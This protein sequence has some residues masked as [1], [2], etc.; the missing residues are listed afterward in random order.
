MKRK[1]EYKPLLFTT[2]LRNPSR[3]KEFLGVFSRFDGQLLTNEV[4]LKI[5]GALISNKLYVTTYQKHN[6]KLNGIYLNEGARYSDR[7]ITD[8]LTHSEQNHKEAGFDRGWPSRFDTWFKFLKELGFLYYEMN[9]TI[10]ISPTGKLLLKANEEG[11]SEFESQAFLNAFV[12]YQ[13]NNPYRRVSNVNK[14]FILLLRTILRLKELKHDNETGIYIF[15]VPYFLSWKD[16]DFN[17]L[18]NYILTNRER[19]GLKP[20]EEVIYDNCK[21]ILD[22]STEDEKRFK[23]S[24]LLHEMPDE[25]IR[26]MRLTG[27]FSLRGMGRYLD[28]N[29]QYSKKIDYIVRTYS[30]CFT[31]SNEHEYFEYASTVDENLVDARQVETLPE[32]EYLSLFNKLVSQFD[33]EILRKEL[34]LLSQKNGKSTNELFRYID[35]PTRLEFL[36]ALL[37]KKTFKDLLVAPN[38]PIDDEGIPTSTAGGNVPDIYCKE[39]GTSILVEVTMLTSTQQNI[40]E[41]PSVIVHLKN[42]LVKNKDSFSVFVAPIVHEQT[43]IFMNLACLEHHISIVIKTIQDFAFEIQGKEKF[44]QMR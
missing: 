13:R 1:N 17:A 3:M 31:F 38:Y 22:L 14:P 24:N 25:F 4:I 9:K 44:S 18:A 10:V 15:E 8:I 30:S 27:V 40:R 16:D 19:Y 20:S 11:G 35:A 34:L 41:T 42:E 2:T 6:P 7:Q 23:I 28:I 12:K 32:S 43:S 36:T 37:L 21:D 33:I 26:K 5:C 39:N 29:T